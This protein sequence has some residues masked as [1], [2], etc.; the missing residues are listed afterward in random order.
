MGCSPTSA[1]WFSTVSAIVVP[2]RRAAVGQSVSDLAQRLRRAA[3]FV[4][5]AVD[6]HDLRKKTT[7]LK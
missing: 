7:S 1:Y 4:G 5:T 6:H 2:P 3:V